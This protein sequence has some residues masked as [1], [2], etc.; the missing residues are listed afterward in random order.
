VASQTYPRGAETS[1]ALAE[2]RAVL[3]RAENVRALLDRP[4]EPGDNPN[5]FNR[6]RDDPDAPQMREA[7]DK[8]IALLD[9]WRRTGPYR[10]PRSPR[11]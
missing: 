8:V 5:D 3:T 7:L 4:T 9:P 10:S 1:R 11:R 2:V 6:W